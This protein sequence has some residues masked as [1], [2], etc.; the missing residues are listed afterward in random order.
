MLFFI[1]DNCFLSYSGSLQRSWI[2]LLN[3]LFSQQ[4]FYFQWKTMYDVKHLQNKGFGDNQRTIKFA[5][6]RYAITPIVL[7]F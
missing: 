4:R 6:N 2:L 7:L 3:K 1:L 5:A